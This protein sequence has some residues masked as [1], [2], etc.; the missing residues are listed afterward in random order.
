[1]A[2]TGEEEVLTVLGRLREQLATGGTT[3]ARNLGTRGGYTPEQE[4][5]WR[6]NLRLWASFVD[7][8]DL[9]GYQG[10]RRVWCNYG[11][12]VG[13]DGSTLT[14]SLEINPPL[15]GRRD[16][17]GL[18]VTEGNGEH[19]L[20][21]KGGL[22]GGRTT[23]GIEQFVGLIQG[24]WARQEVGW[25]DGRR[26]GE[27]FIIGKIGGRDL[28]G[29]LQHYVQEAERIR[30]LVR[31]DS[32]V[33]GVLGQLIGTFSPEFE[34]TSRFARPRQKVE[35]DRSH[36]K[37]VN[38]LR[39]ELDEMGYRVGNAQLG[40]VFPDLYVL[41]P[42]KKMAALFEVKTNCDP[43]T[44]FTGIGQLCVYGQIAGATPRHFL[45][46]PGRPTNKVVRTTLGKMGIT[47]VPFS[48]RRGRVRFDRLK[49]AVRGLPRERVRRGGGTPRRRT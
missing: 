12:D 20:A 2:V 36:G 38:R 6:S 18:I 30:T 8:E 37:A 9:K 42:D 27:Y 35:T 5:I 40:G 21:H 26:P 4:V 47:L 28:P 23:V 32:E 29:R 33:S 11:T 31:E 19:Y 41:G 39:E 46:L 24:G 1:M 14:A 22:G 15:D 17:Y 16:V 48:E 3:V 25:P 10:R 13:D 45:V 34:G 49:Q 7:S 43:Q 44:I